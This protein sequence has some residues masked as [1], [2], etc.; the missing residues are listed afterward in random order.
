ME[1]RAELIGLT[2]LELSENGQNGV[3]H[4][5]GDLDTSETWKSFGYPYYLIDNAVSVRGAASPV[6]TI[7]PGVVVKVANQ[8]CSRSDTGRP[9]R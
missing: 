8:R 9:G 5:G 6:L 4:R 2:G 7:E 1:P 3:R